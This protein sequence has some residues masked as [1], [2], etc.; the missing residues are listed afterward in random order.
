MW[1]DKMVLYGA[2]ILLSTF[3]VYLLISYFGIFFVQRK[4]KGVLSIGL[5]IFIIWQFVISFPISLPVYINI[6]IT[7]LITLVAVTIIYE[8]IW[9]NRCVF[10]IVFNAIWMLME[11]LCNYILVIY[12]EKYAI[13]QPVGS[14]VSKTF[15][16]IVIIA[17]KKVFTSTEIKE[18]PVRYSIMLVLIPIGSIYIMNNIFLLGFAVN[19]NHTC[20]DSAIAAVIL[21]GM[22]ILI[23]YIYVKLSDDLQLR[24]MTS[25]YEQQ[26]E[27]CERHQQER[28]ISTMQL[29]DVKHNMKNNLISILAYAENKDYEKMIEFIQEI[30]SESGMTIKTISNSGNIVVDSLVGYWYAISQK[31]GIEFIV[32]ICIPMTMPFKGA[33]LCLILG[34]LLENAVE[35][36]QKA[37]DKKYIKIKMKYDKGNLLMFVVNSY[38]GQLI[39][40]KNGRLKSTKFDVRNHGIGLLSVCRAAAK[41]H[42]TVVIEDSVPE[43]FKIRL[44]LYGI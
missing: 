38:K 13:I 19:S 7:V 12:C 23:F 25:V 35:A 21:L 5:T 27:L 34:N 44:L 20:F 22:N 36:A 33:D 29:R 1:V 2:N 4:N 28:E 15:F 40:T 26:L 31:K 10:V 32:D 43:Q 41:Y 30:M 16:L 18:M 39:K 42:G 6:I 11:T 24:C 9:W 14:L 37:N 3:A 17:L 8:G